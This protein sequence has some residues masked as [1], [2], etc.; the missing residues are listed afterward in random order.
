MAAAGKIGDDVKTEDEQGN[1]TSIIHEWREK[2]YAEKALSREEAAVAA[3]DEN[4]NEYDI[5]KGVATHKIFPSGASPA[6]DA[7]APASATKAS[8]V[9]AKL[10]AK[11]ALPRLVS[12]KAAPILAHDKRV[13]ANP[14]TR[15]L[16]HKPA[17]LARVR[18]E[19]QIM[20]HTMEKEM[21]AEQRLSMF[22]A[23]MR[24]SM[25]FA[26][27]KLA[28]QE[29]GMPVRRG[30][31]AETDVVHTQSLGELGVGPEADHLTAIKKAEIVNEP[32]DASLI[33]E[34]YVSVCVCTV[35]CVCVCVCTCSMLGSMVSSIF[36][37]SLSLCLSAS[38]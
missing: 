33:S 31:V 32:L 13:A 11:Q 14:L 22:H 5:T 27:M 15:K 21:A 30:P 16:V 2:A 18:A 38:V 35:V 29:M 7:A 25:H 20:R 23:E 8:A 28:H 24:Q 26:Q 19:E 12:K 9:V 34:S 17:L 4:Y 3:K 37:V 1:L 36:Y 6:A 10:A